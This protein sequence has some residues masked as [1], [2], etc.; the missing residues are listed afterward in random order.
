MSVRRSLVWTTLGQLL[1]F[2]FQFGSQVVVSRILSPYEVG[3]A[4]LGFAISDFVNLMQTFGLRNLLVREKDLSGEV[5]KTAFTINAI[6]SLVVGTVVFLGAIW[7]TALYHEPGVGRVLMLIALMP[8]IAIFELLPG[9]LMQ[10]NMEFRQIAFIAVAKAGVTA[11]VTLSCALMGLSYMSIGYGAVAGAFASVILTNIWGRGHVGLGLSLNQWR[12]VTKFGMHMLAIGGVNNFAMKATDLIIGRMLGLSALGL[13]SRASA[14]NGVLWNNIHTVFTRV[15]FSTM[16]EERRTTGSI[17]QSYLKTVDMVTALLWP[18]FAG[19]AVLSAPTIHMIYGAKWMGATPVL[20]MYAIAAV[21]LTSLTMTWEVFVVCEQTG[22]QAR[23]E[24]VRSGL[25]VAFTVFGCL[26]GIQA[27]AASRVADALV[28]FGLYRRPLSQMTETTLAEVAVIY[29]T[30]FV[31]MVLAIGPSV[32]LMSF[33]HWRGD[34]PFVFV[35]ASVLVG[36]ILWVV[37]A[38]FLNPSVT[39]ELALVW[40]KVTRSRRPATA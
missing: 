19:L 29:R 21:V 39:A 8:I 30:N 2:V 24:F 9:A 7:G 11:T 18:A 17:R 31:L 25:S 26:F 20:Q 34:F 32:G 16:A 28:A 5:V 40:A 10:R 22:R 33:F 27:A 4:A 12:P 36:V 37:G 3:V 6:L 14:L 35:L 15:V 23:F 1:L 13:F 38:R